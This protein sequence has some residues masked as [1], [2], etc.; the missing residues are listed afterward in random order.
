MKAA[1][2]VLVLALFA[3]WFF[4][5]DMDDFKVFVEARSGEILQR[6]L[7]GGALGEA[8]SG[9]GARLAGRYIDRI[10]DHDDFLIFSTYTIDL[11]GDGT[12]GEEEWEFLGIGG[13][14]VEMDRPAS[15][16]EER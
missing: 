6:E 12:E 11:D 7:G 15:M 16:R 1:L 4:N 13:Q 14:F 10:T 3:L 5:P 9:A 8:L 2:V